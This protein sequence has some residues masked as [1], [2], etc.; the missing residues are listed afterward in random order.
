MGANSVEVALVKYSSFTVKEAGKPKTYSQ[1][2]VKD[3]TW[4]VDL[5]AQQLDLLLMDHFVAQFEAQHPDLKVRD[6]P[7]A[8]AKLKKQVGKG[9]CDLLVQGPASPPEVWGSSWAQ[10]KLSQQ[11]SVA[12]PIS[13]RSKVRAL[14][15]ACLQCSDLL[16]HISLWFR[17]GA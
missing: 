16:T 4:D 14:A 15:S 12:P 10:A 8:L 9:F 13:R 11:E 6:S 5:G 7:R 1:F 3:V 17:S 2:E